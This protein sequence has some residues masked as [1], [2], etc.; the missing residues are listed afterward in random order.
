[1]NVF[2]TLNNYK[3]DYLPFKFKG[4]WQEGNCFLR[5]VSKDRKIVFLCCQLPNYHGTSITNAVESIRSRA[6]EVLL[7]EVNSNDKPVIDVSLELSLAERLINSSVD[8]ERDKKH[9]IFDFIR[10]NSIWIEHYPAGH[11]I[12]ANGSYAI[13]RF[14]QSGEP[15]W[16]YV[17]IDS[18]FNLVPGFDFNVSNEMLYKWK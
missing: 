7:T 16:N 6:V 8:I 14:S 5:V 3:K 12:D 11:S 2:I 4:F 15:S 1:M 13:V 17:S 9:K 18:L 10:K